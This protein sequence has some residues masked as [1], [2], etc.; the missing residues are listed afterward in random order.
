MN[1]SIEITQIGID[2]ESQ[3]RSVPSKGRAAGDAERD[4]AHPAIGSAATDA[5]GRRRTVRGLLRLSMGLLAV[6]AV[7]VAAVAPA[8]AHGT[9]SRSHI[10]CSRANGWTTLTIENPVMASETDY[11]WMAFQVYSFSQGWLG[12]EQNT[13]GGYWWYS[14]AE[15]VFPSP[16]YDYASGRWDSGISTSH[17]SS[18]RDTYLVYQLFY[19]SDGHYTDNADAFA[20]YQS[21][22]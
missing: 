4:A 3:H 9:H 18:G 10:D 12:W 21:Q 2:T 7:S 11:V 22:C 17:R 20:V 6:V 14:N 15:N 8:S 19:W 13:D 1:A 5:P 16:F